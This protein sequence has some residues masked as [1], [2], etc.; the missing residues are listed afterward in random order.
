MCH[1]LRGVVLSGTGKKARSIEQPVAG[2]T[3][4]TDDYSDAWFVGFSPSLAV[5]VWVGHEKNL[6]PIGRGYAGAKAALPMWIDFVQ[7]AVADRPIEQFVSPGGVDF[8]PI[9]RRTGL[10][11]SSSCPKDQVF[12][13]AFRAGAV[14]ALTCTP[15]H[16]DQLTLPPC[17]QRFPVDVNGVLVVD[18]RALLQLEEER[19][20][21]RIV[22]DPI[23]RVIELPWSAGGVA[24]GAG[25]LRARALPYRPQ[26][27]VWGLRW[28]EDSVE[29][30]MAADRRQLV[31]TPWAGLA[32]FDV[33]DGQTVVIVRNEGGGQGQ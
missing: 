32:D 28:T 31:R 16:H 15:A 1:L 18:E 29:G 5:G 30:R 20:D 2:K 4:T 26:Q 9:D 10:R 7:S 25:G 8:V 33:L 17:L 22:V 19:A 24:D 13:E 12:L 3:G 21:C 6:D 11:A 27:E 14:P 23:R